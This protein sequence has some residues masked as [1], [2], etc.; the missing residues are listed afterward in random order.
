VR[1][2][3]DIGAIGQAGEKAAIADPW[4]MK[5]DAARGDTRTAT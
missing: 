2:A 4:Q 5:E 1:S 3:L